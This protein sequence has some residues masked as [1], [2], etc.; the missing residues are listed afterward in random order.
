[1]GLS[2]DLSF[3]LTRT[4]RYKYDRNVNTQESFMTKSLEDSVTDYKVILI[5]NLQIMHK[6]KTR[7]GRNNH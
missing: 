4:I 3:Y 1:M 7:C 6:E 2:I 5:I